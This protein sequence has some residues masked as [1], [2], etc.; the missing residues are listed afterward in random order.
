MLSTEK[1]KSLGMWWKIIKTLIRIGEHQ[2]VVFSCYFKV[3]NSYDKMFKDFVS[4]MG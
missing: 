1:V 4:D 3:E 2:D